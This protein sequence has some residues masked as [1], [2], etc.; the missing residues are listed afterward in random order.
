MCFFSVVIK[1]ISSDRA[2]KEVW[3]G[4]RGGFKRLLPVD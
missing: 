3:R 2:I 1:I 4:G